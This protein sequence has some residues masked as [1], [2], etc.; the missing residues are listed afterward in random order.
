MKHL[1]AVYDIRAKKFKVEPRMVSG[2]DLIKYPRFLAV[3]R[4]HRNVEFMEKRS[5]LRRLV[6]YQRSKTNLSWAL[7][8]FPEEDLDHYTMEELLFKFRVQ[9]T[10]QN[11]IIMM[12]RRYHEGI[13][14]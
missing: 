3:E 2:E 11:N 12:N 1:I 5:R 7:I 14:L 13:I 4:A 6:Q 9:I 8:T 10:E